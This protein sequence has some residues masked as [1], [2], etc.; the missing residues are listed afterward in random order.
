[1]RLRFPHPL[2]LLL[3]AV[4]V[5]A[6]LTWILPAGEY[7]RTPDPATGR[8]LVVAGTYHEIPAQPVSLPAAML[9]VPR[10]IVSGAD[11]L[12][13][14]LMVGGVFSM[15]ESTGRWGAWSAGR[16]AEGAIRCW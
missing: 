5:A 10:G 4:L 9:A 11:V 6:L 8:E 16:W 13:V 1:M 14:I 3:G 12:L 2:I 15:L 7:Q